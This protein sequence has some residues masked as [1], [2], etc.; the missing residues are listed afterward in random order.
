MIKNEVSTF[1]KGLN[2]IGMPHLI[3]TKANREVKRA[4]SVAVAF[5]TEVEANKAIC[6]RLYIAGISVRVTR[7]FSVASTTQCDN[8]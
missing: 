7:F 1:N 3:S 5:A 6:N 8:F 2:P 4:G